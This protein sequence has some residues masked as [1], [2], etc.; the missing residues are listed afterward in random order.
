MVVPD[1]DVG[2]SSLAAALETVFGADTLL[3]VHGPSLRPQ[4]RRKGL[5]FD[6]KGQRAFVFDIDVS[7]TPSPVR[8]FFAGS[9]M[10]V[11]THQHLRQKDPSCWTVTNKVKLHFVSSEMF[12]VKPQFWLTQGEDGRVRL[13]GRV[14]HHA[15]LPPPLKGIVEKF[16]ALNTSLQLAQFETVLRARA[17]ARGSP[18][19]RLRAA[20]SAHPGGQASHAVYTMTALR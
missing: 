7:G 8:A 3:A 6:S 9:R 17:V 5:E 2:C 16:M 20:L 4:G 12:H 10:S 18:L 19:D 14:R 15:I 13:G 11:T 1:V